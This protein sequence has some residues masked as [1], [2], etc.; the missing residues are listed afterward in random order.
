MKKYLGLL[1][2]LSV[3]PMSAAF[4]YDEYRTSSSQYTTTRPSG[5]YKKTSSVRRTGGYHNTI[6]NNFYYNQPAETTVSKRSQMYRD[7]DNTDVT[8][9]RYVERTEQTYSSQERK[10]FLA[11][12]FFQP[13]KGKFGSVTD[14]AYAKNSF[15][16]DIL[17]GTIHDVDPYSSTTGKSQAYLNTDMFGAGKA[18]QSQFL[19]KEDLS[20]GLTDTLALVLM[21]QYDSTK[22]KFTDLVTGTGEDKDSDS[23]LRLFGIGL[24]NRFVDNDEWIA[25]VTGVFQHQKDAAN[26][27]SLEMKA[28]YKINRTTVYGLARFAYSD[29]INGESYGAIVAHPDGD[30]LEL[31]YDNNVNDVFYAEV[32]AGVFSVLDKYFYLGGEL[33]FG[34]YDWHNQIN[35]KG[36]IGFQP[37]DFFALNLYASTALYDSADNKIRTYMQNDLDPG[38]PTE[39]GN[40]AGT[41]SS[42]FYT[43]G[44]YKLDNYKEWKIGVQAILY[45]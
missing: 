2:L 39:L 36:T 33:V 37:R 26:T 17:N 11:H 24:Q 13:L 35:I 38:Y 31:S 1:A 7:Y 42:H 18:E 43:T 12:P 22:T 40:L 28:G 19:V 25:M 3:L 34:H 8:K 6:N 30:Y 20:F 10:Y 41:N 27:L 16:F 45:F 32:G 29:L 5:T 4:G 23:G 44:D 9:S 21:A 15:N 14:I